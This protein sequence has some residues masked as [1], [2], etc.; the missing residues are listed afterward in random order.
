VLGR[1]ERWNVKWKTDSGKRNGGVGGGSECAVSGLGVGRN[2]GKDR[3]ADFQWQ[4][5][6]VLCGIARRPEFKVVTHLYRKR[7]QLGDIHMLEIQVG[8]FRQAEGGQILEVVRI[9]SQVE[10]RGG[11]SGGRLET[12]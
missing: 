12:P 1:G 3:P 10:I 11:V 4:I 9:R 7:R 8:A 5:E 2:E 6:G